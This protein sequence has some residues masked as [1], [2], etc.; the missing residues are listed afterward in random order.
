VAA[1]K[2]GCNSQSRARQQADIRQF[3]RANFQI[4]ARLRSR[5]RGCGIRLVAANTEVSEQKS[6]KKTTFHNCVLQRTRKE[7]TAFR[8]PEGPSEAGRIGSGSEGK[9]PKLHILHASS[10][11]LPLRAGTNPAAEGRLFLSRT[12]VLI[13]FSLWSPCLCGSE[14][15]CISERIFLLVVRIPQIQKAWRMIR[16]NRNDL[17][18]HMIENFSI[19]PWNPRNPW[20]FCFDFSMIESHFRL[21]SE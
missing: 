1:T 9:R 21:Y 13:R 10:G 16:L 11:A 5:L 14:I 4:S 17:P 8:G 3:V 7:E 18:R 19:N 12:E 15:L 6:V 20:R 2:V